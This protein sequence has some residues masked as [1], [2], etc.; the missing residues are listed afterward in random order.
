LK[1]S[2]DG[3]PANE[4]RRKWIAEI[5]AGGTGRESIDKFVCKMFFVLLDAVEV[6]GP[7]ALLLAGANRRIFLLIHSHAEKRSSKF[8]GLGIRCQGFAANRT[9]NLKRSE[10]SSNANIGERVGLGGELREDESLNYHPRYAAM[11]SRL[12]G[13]YPLSKKRSAAASMKRYRFIRAM[14]PLT[15]RAMM[16]R[17]MP[18]A[19]FLSGIRQSD[20]NSHLCRDAQI[21][22]GLEA[23]KSVKPAMQVSPYRGP[24]TGAR[25][26]GRARHSNPTAKGFHGSHNV[27]PCIDAEL[28]SVCA[29]ARSCPAS[30]PFGSGQKRCEPLATKNSS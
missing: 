13:A 21:S 19:K 18:F 7:F 28:V 9:V 8:P 30:L 12:V 1:A 6:L 3:Y 4:S 20:P 26:I 22:F 5:A 11:S 14:S 17:S 16:L 10:R 24:L 15:T 2:P 29:A 25:R 23:D 27:R